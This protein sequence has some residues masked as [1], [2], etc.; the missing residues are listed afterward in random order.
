MNTNIQSQTI[1]ASEAMRMMLRGPLPLAGHEIQLAWAACKVDGHMHVDQYRALRAV[2]ARHPEGSHAEG[3][4]GPGQALSN[5]A[6]HAHGLE[7]N[8]RARLFAITAWVTAADGRTHGSEVWLLCELRRALSLDPQI[9][10][11]LFNLARTA[12][13]EALRPPSL[14]ELKALLS[15]LPA[16]SAASACPA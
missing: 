12:R 11:R 13:L 8:D 1:P 6:R 7:D 14:G 9:A 2:L 16:S 10:R 4:S 5:I 3:P 15:G